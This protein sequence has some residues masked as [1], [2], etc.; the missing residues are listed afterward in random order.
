M[1]AIVGFSLRIEDS[2]IIVKLWPGKS[3]QQKQQLADE[4]T[5][6]V[7]SVL[8]TATNPSR[9]A[10]RKSAPATGWRRSTSRHRRPAGQPLQKPGYGA[11]G[12]VMKTLA[13]TC[14]RAA[15]AAPAFAQAQAAA[16]APDMT[17]ARAG[18]QASGKGPAQYF[19]GSARVDP[20]FPHTRRRHL[21]RLRHFRT[22]RA[23][24]LAHASRGPGIDRDGRR[25]PRAA[26]GRP[27]PGDPSRRR[28]L[29][30]AR[31]QALARRRAHHLA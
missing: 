12:A 2:H 3:R 28:D 18:S 6:S 9:S 19:T 26:L 13:A 29:D 7:T 4:I 5:R 20:L 22:G 31:R 25:R 8:D 16:D 11:G 15:V 27:G 17:I 14:M 1:L 30:P 23:L 24:G 10:S 21:G